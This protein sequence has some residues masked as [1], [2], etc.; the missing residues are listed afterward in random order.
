MATMQDLMQ[1]AREAGI[2]SFLEDLLKGRHDLHSPV[3]M[4]ERHERRHSLVAAPIVDMLS[5]FDAETLIELERRFKP[6]PV[7]TIRWYDPST[8]TKGSLAPTTVDPEATCKQGAEDV[9]RAEQRKFPLRILWL[10]EDDA[11]EGRIVK[12]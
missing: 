4:L 9:M 10:V 6:R 3:E 8:D 2:P 11:A 1:G 12:P 7:Y 5:E